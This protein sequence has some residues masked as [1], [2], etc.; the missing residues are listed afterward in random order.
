MRRPC[1]FLIAIGVMVG[2]GAPGLELAAQDRASVDVLRLPARI[3]LERASVPEALG[4]L[5][6]GSGVPIAF[7]P[8]LLSSGIRVSCHCLDASVGEALARILE[9]SGFGFEVVRGQIIIESIDRGATWTAV[10]GG[11]DEALHGRVINRRTSQPLAGATVHIPGT[12]VATTTDAQGHFSLKEVPVQPGGVEAW[13]LGYATVA[14]LERET[15]GRSWLEIQMVERPLEFDAIV[16]TGSVGVTRRRE[17]GYAISTV[18]P[19]HLAA[20]PS[21]TEQL[22]QSRAVGV[23][24]TPAGGSLGAGAQIRLR[25]NVSPWLSNHPLVY[26][27]GVRQSSDSYASPLIEGGPSSLVGPSTS[28]LNDVNPRDIARIEVVK[29]AAA[30]SLYGSEAASGVIQIFT[31]RGR[32]GGASFTYQTDQ[33]FN[34]VRPFGSDARPF[35]NM[36]PFLRT[37]HT[38]SHSASVT[39]GSSRTGYFTSFL[40]EDGVGV[41]R[42]SS[43]QRFSARTNLN[44]RVSD[45]FGVSVTSA[46]SRYQVSTPQTGGN[47]YGLEF[48]AFR[49]PNNLVG[50]ADPED[51]L[52][53]VHSRMDRDNRRLNFGLS[54]QFQ[55]RSTLTHS[56]T[57]GLDRMEMRLRQFAPHGFVLARDGFVGTKQWVSEMQTLDYEFAY[58]PPALGPVGSRIA[59][60][61]QLR[62]RKERSQDAFGFGLPGPGDHAVEDAEER[63]VQGERLRTVTGGVFTQ[64][65]LDIEERYFLTLGLRLD[66]SSTFGSNLGLQPYPKASASWVL[67]EES[68]WQDSWGDFRVRAAFGYAGRAPLAFE[69]RRSWRGH[70]VEGGQAFLPHSTGNSDLAPERT[71]EIDLGVESVL[72]GGRVELALAYYGQVT[73][74]ALFPVQEIP[75]SGFPGT[76]LRNVGRLS[77][78][79]IEA[80]ARATLLSRAAWEWNAGL[81]LATNRNRVL[82]LAGG[83]HFD[84][85]VGHPAPVVRGTRVLNPDEYADPVFEYNALHGPNQPTRILGAWSSIMGWKGVT[86]SARLEYQGGH[87]IRDGASS[88]MASRGAGAAACDDRAYRIVP[89]DAFPDH[90]SVNGLTALERARCYGQRGG[91]DFRVW[92]FPA[93]FLKMRDLTVL[94]PADFLVPGRASATV[95]ASLGNLLVWK[96]RDF[97]SFDPESAIDMNALDRHINTLTPAPANLSLSLRVG[98]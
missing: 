8:S 3:D 44:L 83:E 59:V 22:L 95:V 96:H 1:W 9:G 42:T 29:G 98:F 27:D 52:E 63:R 90:P 41:L 10:V 46:A 81:S 37:G 7:S 61:V 72:F 87:F 75:S 14:Q 64:A 51:L 70:E 53:L 25:G 28:P 93:D 80:E 12:R 45:R 55:Q 84:F 79:G 17:I 66:G 77:N 6:E 97:P 78:R 4:K 2:P 88:G 11:L 13:L 35:L 65:I 5:R 62:D 58:R 38:Q 56:V 47:L 91:A 48:N 68:F 15:G 39:G 73:E 16:V 67:S 71:R 30:T 19:D 69:A 94:V 74:R 50:S 57:F 34:R 24:V 21:T 92:I 33:V 36:E 89:F 54:S 26:I 43:S 86:V 82:D 49:A 18:E 76:Q 40:V 32:E 60:G 23:T 85:V 20:L 31:K